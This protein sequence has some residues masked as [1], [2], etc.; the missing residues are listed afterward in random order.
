MKDDDEDEE[1]TFGVTRYPCM[2][3]LVALQQ[4]RNRLHLAFLGRKLMKWT[5]TATGRE[6]R[7]IAGEIDAIYKGFDADLRNAYI[8]LARSRYFDPTLNQMVL[9]NIPTKAAVMVVPTAK[10]VSGVKL[11]NYTIIETN[12]QNYV[13]L[14]LE[15][16]GQ[17][18]LETKKAWLELLKRLISMLQLRTSFMTVEISNRAATKKYNVLSKMVVPRVKLSEKY[19]VSEMEEMEREDNFRLKRFKE[20][21]IKKNQASNAEKCPACK[22]PIDKCT[23]EK[24]NTEPKDNECVCVSKEEEQIIQPVSKASS[25]LDENVCTF[26]ETV[27]DVLREVRSSPVIAEEDKQP[28]QTIKEDTVI[29]EKSCTCIDNSVDSNNLCKTIGT[30]KEVR[31]SPVIAEEDKQPVQII[32]E[33]T[34]IPEKSCTC[35]DNSVDSNNLCK[36]IGT[37]KEVR[38]SPVIAE[39]DKQPVQTI[40]DDTVTPKKS[41]TCIDNSVDWNNLCKI[42]GTVKLKELKDI[43]TEKSRQ[44]Q[45][46]CP[47]EPI[48]SNSMTKTPEKSCTCMPKPVNLEDLCRKV[49]V[50]DMQRIKEVYLQKAINPDQT[51]YECSCEP[52]KNKSNLSEGKTDTKSV[53]VPSITHECLKCQN[54]K[55]NESKNVSIN[56]NENKDKEDTANVQPQQDKDVGHDNTDAKDKECDCVHKEEERIVQPVSKSSAKL[57]ENVCTFHE[58]V[59]DVLREVCS[60]PLIAEEDK[61]QVQIIKEATVTPEKSC[62]CIDNSVDWNSLGKII[63]TEKLKEL[64]DIYTAKSKQ[65][66]N[67]C[68]CGPIDSKSITKTPEKSCSCIP[69]PVNLE[70]LCSKVDVVEMQR[71]KDIYLQ[72]AINPDQSRYECSCE[73]I[74]NKSNLSEGKSD[75]KLVQVQSNSHECLKCRNIKSKE[76]KKGS[77]NINKNKNKQD[78]TN[79]QPQQDKDNLG[80]SQELGITVTEYKEF[81]TV[82][83]Y[84]KEDGTIGEERQVVTV[85]SEAKK[86]NPPNPDTQSC[87]SCKSLKQKN[88]SST[89]A[90]V[91]ITLPVEKK[92]SETSNVSVKS[93]T[94]CKMNASGSNTSVDSRISFKKIACASKAAQTGDKSKGTC[95]KMNKENKSTPVTKSMDGKSSDTCLKHS[96]SNN[97][98]RAKSCCVIKIVSKPKDEHSKDDKLIGDNCFELLKRLL[99]ESNKSNASKPSVCSCQSKKEVK[100]STSQ[101]SSKTCE[102]TKSSQSLKSEKSPQYSSESYFSCKDSTCKKKESESSCK[103]KSETKKDT[104][105]TC[106][107]NVAP[108]KPVNKPSECSCGKSKPAKFESNLSVLSYDS[109]QKSIGTET[110]CSKCAKA[111][112]AARNSACQQPKPEC[113]LCSK[114]TNGFRSKSDSDIQQKCWI[115]PK[116]ESKQSKCPSCAQKIACSC[117]SAKPNSQCSQ[118]SQKTS[119]HSKSSVQFMECESCREQESKEV[120]QAK[121]CIQPKIESKQSKCPIC[122]QKNACSCNSAKPN[123]QCSQDSQKTAE[124]SKSSV[125]FME[126]ESC[127]EQKSKE[128]QQ[129]K[130]CIQPK[131]ESK[132]SKCPIC[133]QKNACSC[134]SAKPNSQCSQDSQK[135]AE[136]SK[137][138]VQFMECESC[139]EQKSKEVQQAKCCIQPK[140]ESKQSKCPICAQKNACS[141]N[142]AKPNSQCSQDSQKTAEPSKSS[143]QFMECESCREQKSKEVQQAKCC[144]QPKIESKQSKCPICAQKN[145]CSCNSA[146]PNSQCSQDSQKTAEPSKSSVQFME[147]ESC[148]EQ[149]S[150]EVQ[151]AKCCIQPK[152]ESKQSKCPICAQKNACSC[153]SAKPNSQCSQDSQKTAEPSK[154]SVQFMECESCREQKSKEVQQAECCI[155]TK[156]ESTQSKCPICAQKSAC[157]C[158]S[159]KPN[160]QCSQDSKKNSEHSKSSVQFVESE[161]CCEPKSKEVGTST[162]RSDRY[163]VRNI[164]MLKPNKQST[165]TCSS[166]SYSR[167]SVDKWFEPPP[168]ANSYHDRCLH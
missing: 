152:I 47:C 74:K 103:C 80:G 81:V 91:K 125:Q 22:L 143:V 1:N 138:S 17:T 11:M 19:I 99:L 147:C 10:A 38:S 4:M 123:S 112:S 133:A 122:A 73:P 77:M 69:K 12:A 159:A 163:D 101:T 18:I 156:L 3:S 100:R 161:I 84:R 118:D 108:P 117:N 113:P 6:M 67:E 53:Q 44:S 153:N 105:P 48:E 167:I 92:S 56:I 14:G 23:C 158:N 166:A 110:D 142:S 164:D 106:G 21:K 154:S 128:V 51:Q 45:N 64:Q 151:Q 88:S 124:P 102:C 116:L 32:K 168:K 28:V 129:A 155:Q 63:G 71:I 54:I 26:H 89:Q 27:G 136:P 9:E 59:G 76:S 104:C 49:D 42:I 162:R 135:T 139:R 5:M 111:Q 15:K 165:C 65:S 160:R 115:Q 46:E 132:Q 114:N 146:K 13:H 35:I 24:P 55:S 130:C 87:L 75:T 60:C 149:K 86:P 134:N 62:T 83:R 58:T 93:C 39:E 37:E 96:S 43:Y 94:I 16:G 52:I 7:R 157:S 126:C 2:P 85:K 109:L 127:R 20:L 82:K 98:D 57:D 31:S 145:A 30:E 66:Q 40:K 61:H 78:T 29:P 148:R 107:S 90:K 41:C 137:S 33:D 8:L 120:Q 150:K 144:I 121:F 25:T 72:K 95:C 34:V 140:I 141:C 70:D 36:T 119:E 50:E 79:V 131:I 68:P 97:T